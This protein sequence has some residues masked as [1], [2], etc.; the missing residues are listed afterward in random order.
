MAR[1]V[2]G[3]TGGIASG[4]SSV[5]A[6][7]REN[8]VLV[9]DADEIGHQVICPPGPVY[10]AILAHF[11]TE[12]RRED[13]MIDRKRLG[14]IVF[15]SREERETLNAIVHPAIRRE[16][17]RLLE[18]AG[19]AVIDAALLFEANM[20]DLCDEIWTV[21][22]REDTQIRRLMRRDGLTKSEARARIAS[23]LSA[24]E[25]RSRAD[26]II[27]NNGTPAQLRRRVVGLLERIPFL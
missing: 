12:I 15:A 27:D 4:K 25:R 6:L 22:V 10:D 5:A 26:V 9:I 3:L 21:D 8:G 16:I 14:R 20:E 23:Q 7:L 11:G 1:H 24:A 18:E 19:V 13:G 17:L 2:I